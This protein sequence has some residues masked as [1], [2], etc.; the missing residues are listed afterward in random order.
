M[1]AITGGNTLGVFNGFLPPQPGQSRMGSTGEAAWVN[2]ANGNLVLQRTDQILN[3]TGFDT[4]LLRTYNSQARYA[5]DNQDGWWL[6]GYR[7]VLNQTG[8][9]N[10]SGSSVQRVDSDGA[11]QTYLWDGERYLQHDA[12]GRQAS[13]RWDATGSGWV[14]QQDTAT[15]RAERYET[16]ADGTWRL[17]SCTDA[18]GTVEVSYG[19][20][21]SNSTY[22]PQDARLLTRITAANGET[23]QLVYNGDL[24]MEEQVWHTGSPAALYSSTRYEYDS[25]RRLS[26]VMVDL[27]PED[28]SV[29]DGHVYATRYTYVGNGNLVASV[30]QTDGS[31]LRLGYVEVEG[32]DRVASMTD[33]LGYITLFSYNTAQRSTTVTDALGASTVY[34][35]D[36]QGRFE[37][38]TGPGVN[39]H[40]QQT[41]YTWDD[42]GNMT[43]Q[44]QASG[45]VITFAYDSRGH[46]VRQQDSAGN[47][48]E[49]YWNSLDQMT[50]R[51]T[52]TVVD[53]DGLAGPGQASGRLTTRYLYGETG[54]MEFMIS[55]EGT[56]S[57]YVYSG[58]KLETIE[59]FDSSFS[60]QP[61][62]GQRAPDDPF[63]LDD[64]ELL[65][66]GLNSRMSVLY[67]H[68]ARG[69]MILSRQRAANGVSEQVVTY[70]YD[71]FGNLLVRME[72]PEMNPEGIASYYSHDG[73]GRLLTETDAEG[74]TRVHVWD[75][76]GG[77]TTHTQANG[78][79]D[80]EL[81]DANGRL[82]STTQGGMPALRYAYDALG[83]QVLSVDAAGHQTRSLYD[84]NGNRVA[85][86]T[87]AGALTE[88]IY[89]AAGQCSGE[90]RYATLLSGLQLAA[91][92]DA[93]GTPLDP[94][95]AA[96][97]PGVTTADAS[98]WQFH[99]LAG[100]LALTVDGTGNVTSRAYDGVGNMISETR[101]AIPVSLP[102]AGGGAPL[103]P[104]ASDADR[105]HYFYHDGN[106]NL[107]GEIDAE[108]YVTRY[109]RNVFGQSIQT[110]RHATRLE[111]MPDAATPFSQLIPASTSADQ[112][113]FF[114]YSA[115][116]TLRGTVDA[117]HY[118]TEVAYDI[119]GNK[120][121]EIRH[122]KPIEFN[123]LVYERDLS[124]LTRRTTLAGLDQTTSYTWTRLNQLSSKTNSD[125]VR[126]EY[127]YDAMGQLTATT[128]AAGTLDQRQNLARYD[129]QG[130]MIAT[131]AGEGAYRLQ[132]ATTPAAID[133]VWAEWGTVYAYD[134]AGQQISSEIQNPDGSRNVTRYLYDDAGRLIATV[135][136]LGEASAQRWNAVGQL[137]ETR[138]YQQRLSTAQLS[139]LPGISSTGWAAIL[140]TLQHAE[141]RITRY[142]YDAAGRQSTIT[143]ALQQT[144]RTQYNA[145]GELARSIRNM[146]DGTQVATAYAYD[147]RGQVTQITEDEGGSLSRSTHTVYDPF[148]RVTQTMDAR[149][150]ATHYSYD[151]R[152]RQI[153]IRDAAGYSTSTVYDSRDRKVS[154]TDSLGNVTRWAYDLAS[155]T[156]T[157][158]EG[159]STTTHPNDFGQIVALTDGMGNVTRYEYDHSGQ[160]I[161]ST[162]VL[163]HVVTH[164]FNA[165]GQEW[166]T[167]DAMG[168]VTQS[169]YDPVGR[170]LSKTLDPAG[171]ALRTSWQ[172]DAL[173]QQLSVATG[174]TRQPAQTVT[175]YSYDALGQLVLATQDPDGLAIRT[176]Y[177]HD[178][179]GQVIAI[180]EAE[181][182]PAQKLT[183][184]TFDALG[185]RTS[186]TVDP[187]GLNI[188]TTYRYDAS[189]NLIERIADA[190]G[191]RATS[192]Y[193]Y[194]ALNRLTLSV[195]AMG[196]LTRT[197][198][199]SAGRVIEVKRFANA[200]DLTR[201]A[202][203]PDGSTREAAILAL[204]KPLSGKDPV[205]TS[206]YDRDGRPGKV[207]DA[208]GTTTTYTWNANGQRVSQHLSGT[209]TDQLTVYQLDKAGRTVAE[210]VAHGTDVAS[211][212]R[213][214]YDASG[215]LV[216]QTDPLGVE[217][218]ET[219]SAWA[220]AERQ[221]LHYVNDLGTRKRA[222]DLSEGERASLRGRYTT[223]WQYDTAGRQTSERDPL[224]GTTRQEQDARG[225]VVRMTDALGHTGYF[226]YDALNRLTGQVDPEGYLTTTQYSAN[227]QVSTVTRYMTRVSG[228]VSV[229]SMPP[230][231]DGASAVT[232]FSHDLMGRLLI[233]TDA[234]QHTERY[235]W[236]GL[237]HKTSYTNTLNAT[238][239]YQYD[240]R[241]L[242]LQETLPVHT[243][244]QTGEPVAVINRYE[245]DCFGNRSKVIEAA[246][247]REQRITTYSHDLLNRLLTTTGEPLRAD[248][249]QGS[250]SVT[251]TSTQSWNAAG[252]LLSV[253]DANGNTTRY[254]YDAANR[255]TGQRTADGTETR[256][257]LDAAGNVI[258]QTVTPPAGQG[259]ART[260]CYSYDANRQ[261][262]ETRIPQIR[263]ANRAADNK[264]EIHTGDLCTRTVYNAQ[265][266]AVETVDANGNTTYHFYDRTGH[267]LLQVDAAGYG[268]AWQ[269]DAEGHV[270]QETRYALGSTE[271]V[272]SGLEA[273]ALIRNWPTDASQDRTTQYTYDLLG[274]R[275]SETRLNVQ[276]GG[277]SSTGALATTTGG[278]STRYAYDNA[279][280]L[281][282]K[283]DAAHNIYR[284]QYDGLG[285]KTAD[286]LPVT[287]GYTGR[288]V[289]LQVDYEYN[290]LNQCT[291]EARRASGDNTDQITH[292]EYG[293]GGRL[294]RKTDARGTQF[295]FEYD[296][297]GNLTATRYVRTTNAG[298]QTE[299]IV[300]RYDNLNRETLRFTE[301][302]HGSSRVN[303]VNSHTA[304]NGFSEIT[305]RETG[306]TDNISAGPAEFTEYDQAG[307]V[308]RSNAGN[309]VTH[310][311]LYDANGNATVQYESQ[312]LDLRTFDFNNEATRVAAEQAGE[313]FKTI[314]LYDRRNQIEQIVQPDMSGLGE[315]P[316]LQEVPGKIMPGSYQ[317]GVSG[318]GAIN[319]TPLNTAAGQPA[320]NGGGMSAAALNSP[321]TASWVMQQAGGWTGNR[322]LRDPQTIS[323]LWVDTTVTVPDLRALGASRYNVRFEMLIDGVTPM[324][325]TMGGI[326]SDNPGQSVTLSGFAQ[327][328]TT[329]SSMAAWTPTIIVIA[330]VMNGN[331]REIARYQT[332]SAIATPAVT[333]RRGDWPWIKRTDA[334]SATCGQEG[335][336]LNLDPADAGNPRVVVA[337]RLGSIDAFQKLDS[338][339]SRIN[340]GVLANGDYEVLQIVTNNN[341]LQ[342]REALAVHKTASN[343]WSE[344]IP[345]NY[346]ADSAFDANANGTFLISS[347]YLYMADVKTRTGERGD[348]VEMWSRPKGST[349]ALTYKGENHQLFSAWYWPAQSGDHEIEIRIK[350]NG[351][352]LL[353]TLSGTFRGGAAPRISVRSQADTTASVLTITNL[354]LIADR[355]SS[356]T[357]VNANGYRMD[358]T[359][360][361]TL[362]A[363]GALRVDIPANWVST[364]NNAGPWT[365][366]IQ[367]TTGVERDVVYEG[368]GSIR[369]GTGSTEAVITATRSISAISF[370]PTI[371]GAAA[372][373]ISYRPTPRTEADQMAAS[374][375][376]TR[377]LRADGSV[378]FALEGLNPVLEVEYRYDILDGNGAVIST[379]DGYFTLNHHVSGKGATGYVSSIAT[380]AAYTIHRQQTHNAFGE[381]ASETDGR[382]Y[383]EGNAN[384]ALRDQY[385]TTLE[386]NTQG[387][388]T[389]KIA[390][391]VQ[392]TLANGYQQLARPETAYSY[393]VLG[394]VVAM[395][396]ANGNLTTQAWAMAGGKA[397]VIQEWHAD[398]GIKKYGYDEFGNRRSQTDEL[399][400]RTDYHYTQNNQIDQVDHPV[401]AG[402][403]HIQDR[404][405][406]DELGQRIRHTQT[407]GSLVRTD[408]TDYDTA[409]RVTRTVSAAGRITTLDFTHTMGHWIRTTTQANG[410]DV[411]GNRLTG[412][413]LTA[414]HS[415][416]V[417]ETDAFGRVIRHTGLGGTVSAYE[418]N[419]A[420]LLTRQDQT[421]YAYYGNGLVR[422]MT[423]TG[424]GNRG[425][426]E[427]DTDGNRV[428]E[429][430]SG[431]NNLYYYQTTAT[432]DG[433]NRLTHLHDGA[434]DASGKALSKGSLFDISYEFDAAGNRIRM[435]SIYR[436]A[437][438]GHVQS[439]DYWYA[440]DSL[441]RFT[442]T[443][444]RLASGS[445]ALSAAALNPVVSTGTASGVTLAYN[446]ASQRTAA[447]TASNGLTSYYSYD[448]NGALTET[449]VSDGQVFIRYNDAAGREF[450]YHTWNAQGKKTTDLIRTWDADNLL[451]DEQDQMNRTATSYERMRDGTL[452]A[453]Q[454]RA[455]HPRATTL[456]TVYSYVYFDS[457][458]QADIKI[459]ASNKTVDE[460]K[461]TW[462]PGKSS[463]TYDAYG[464]LTQARDVEANRTFSYDHDG[465]GKVLQRNEY[466]NN[467]AQ[468]RYHKYYYFEGH[469]VGNIG[470]DGIRNLDYVQE[471]AQRQQLDKDASHKRTGPVSAIDFTPDAVADFDSNYQPVNSSYPGLAPSSY[472][473]RA[474]DTLRSVAQAL[475]GDADM[476][477]LIADANGML[478]NDALVAGTVLTIP[479]RVTNIHNNAGTFKVYDPGRAIGN[480]QPTLPDPPPP[481]VPASSGNRCGVLGR[482]VL[483]VVAVVATIYTTGLAAESLGAALT[484]GG[485]SASTMALGGAALSGGTTLGMGAAIGAAA[486]GGAAGSVAAQGLN[487]LAGNQ[488]GLN[489]KGVAMGAVGTA[490]TAG[491]GSYFNAG[492]VAMLIKDTSSAVDYLS[493]A[494]QAALRS[495]ATQTI[496]VATGLQHNFD[497]Q[498][499]AAGAIAAGVAFGVGR[500]LRGTT[501]PAP[502]QRF[503]TGMA[504]GVISAEV[505]GNLNAENLTGIT[506]DVLGSTLGMQ[507]SEQIAAQQ[508]QRNLAE[509][510]KLPP[511]YWGMTAESGGG[512]RNDAGPVETAEANPLRPTNT[513]AIKL[514]EK[515]SPED[516]ALYLEAEK[517]IAAWP[518]TPIFDAED[519]H[520]YLLM[521]FFDGTGNDEL[522]M[523]IPTNVSEL[524]KLIATSKNVW[525]QYYKGVGTDP[526]T[527]IIGG[528]TGAG[529]SNRINEAYH[530]VIKRANQIYLD[531]PNAKLTFVSVGFSRGSAIGRIYSNHMGEYGI[532][533][534]DSI[535]SV[536]SQDGSHTVYDRYLVEPGKVDI[537]AQIL[538]DTVSTGFGDLYNLSILESTQNV[539]H[540]TARDEFRH[541]FGLTSA[542]DSPQKSDRRI[543]EITLPGAHSDIGGSYDRGGLGDMNL[544][545]AQ[546]YTGKLGIP[547]K[548]KN[549]TLK[550]DLSKAII[551]D[552][553]WLQ[554]KMRETLFSRSSR[555]IDY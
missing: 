30:T 410:F 499:L 307:R 404:Y 508:M 349:G 216:A 484:A 390:P 11:V 200:L 199:D 222:A 121:R 124:W 412:E 422:D 381:I 459:Q 125:G 519:P 477:W 374:T 340:L 409:G 165:Q 247:A 398:G 524:R 350:R 475:W 204:S 445:R 37:S 110:T 269:Y 149:G 260:T 235:S 67:N 482:I 39:G 538:F 99:D 275:T 370:T 551:H 177:T 470:N 107:A 474:G 440:Y 493:V 250:R 365:M 550:P 71:A 22:G 221:A 366:E 28:M 264:V 509:S 371:P 192:R 77:R 56:T 63:T 68:D 485:T 387:Q 549:A 368:K 500:G 234:S 126:T 242:L 164:D 253:T 541:G 547:L 276:T 228:P 10:T 353:D 298:S 147:H 272:T 150:K 6:N 406:V 82:I 50:A 352:V 425:H 38:V 533:D 334:T 136:A 43:S 256:Y 252:R 209:G 144:T 293:T 140:A 367:A 75:D 74:H 328:Q 279:G 239:A 357:L 309:G 290:G 530:D 403:Q 494:G 151:S 215:R 471:M 153:Q 134:S 389:R 423:D 297:N 455:D 295:D 514:G 304:Y 327:R 537:G 444:G 458:Q 332:S 196:G 131:L 80:T 118:F 492:N 294:T 486:I 259:A 546:E 408:T 329:A 391:Q 191:A 532:P 426:Y 490:V 109:L 18:S 511:G 95:L 148:G 193:A 237:G 35:H 97:R 42:A 454:T 498:G 496:G 78:R 303:G 528:L 527:E 273:G 203:L 356:F 206:S 24:L 240:L 324:Y 322:D 336:W 467:N 271:V 554:D 87:P 384:K 62:L 219:D 58:E 364:L 32:T 91:L 266:Q 100:R 314:T 173:G 481:P 236:N 518:V 479:N 117:A 142:T 431:R 347:Q 179:R 17:A 379:V 127:A 231:P 55:P 418:Y 316:G 278:V 376:A 358:L 386:Y 33:A 47:V 159:I 225:N 40:A 157:T 424:S 411:A 447:T 79:T 160:L 355:I 413:A 299:R 185:R 393:D 132:G 348:Y 184:Y 451:L 400:L 46:L 542:F 472:T 94:G 513:N 416:L 243:R 258:S 172:W 434:F 359:R 373:R 338:Y 249:A 263:Q 502:A 545:F 306:N 439:Q 84:A 72:H 407:A 501:L 19:Y 522:K 143:D 176:R 182:T 401:L 392:I 321:M 520:Q 523:E 312:A 133:A 506:G 257:T 282:Q 529:I 510:T 21:G 438:G 362:Q 430:Y 437:L 145:F 428:F 139:Q 441:N 525:A 548:P 25:Q 291:Q 251:P 59:C 452:L 61:G 49:Q 92:Y 543:L 123:G 202:S 339:G 435:N 34:V 15:R 189:D 302:M 163:G 417:D 195:D 241:G 478:G 105:T 280:N 27:S 466:I 213:Y 283:T 93:T 313:L 244:N 152:G 174:T 23:V 88:F 427:Y 385:T 505:R 154:S 480:T 90:I 536:Q 363:G 405:T 201:L 76:A 7:R 462:A 138:R 515:L 465:E 521:S 205:E 155:F 476:W 233:S 141:D 396:D 397:Q 1:V 360:Y 399:G 254:D 167:T 223:T 433:M 220:S 414:S 183:Q 296:A 308:F 20:G 89:D 531:D 415:V 171:L 54:Q 168:V 330:H 66:D 450:A 112:V 377:N 289:Q 178:A 287:T 394:N 60:S 473:A 158:P 106:G 292:F 53:P 262:V 26:G 207:T 300:S 288:A 212:T 382:G 268:I 318:S 331:E 483:V 461:K 73:L 248:D 267:K 319:A 113:D 432:W 44:T 453:T 9:L 491:V 443:M 305:G 552:S 232:Q 270:L 286:I 65:L 170:L 16:A 14:W 463:F 517:T 186:E 284:W 488:S 540:L 13:L 227:G 208:N 341:G 214:R 129:A 255:K 104:A 512:I 108:G 301:V 188:T 3:A 446:R 2:T 4:A 337:R 448:N 375:V 320:I 226:Y 383:S 98:T 57:S 469:E 175:R 96:L 497:W 41:R 342:R 36:A 86:I 553:R 135:N 395:Q 218:A 333:S 111:H 181:G 230:L 210:T 146:G 70:Y 246:G 229:G 489:W 274:R 119:R 323:Q 421:T 169:D 31:T 130:R 346:T 326:S 81:R 190:S 534:L 120:L 503:A 85:V 495:A 468:N 555:S 45:L 380:D 388:L 64:L 345:A 277:I 29:A 311:W 420:G 12:N 122:G 456:R 507:V 487:I 83:R 114:I 261:L 197:S 344:A 460:W 128:S 457:A 315:R 317:L 52:Y 8:N 429:G 166:Q 544:K 48:L 442:V 103:L 343:T 464:R 535:R 281:V 198:H 211:T 162:D 516:I 238:T 137:A 335:S 115:E 217:L 402:D 539:L 194:D 187:A 101:H 351:G 526:G 156:V 265:G 369:F 419:Y 372:I 5:D 285:R 449:R 325:S 51:V 102:A 504:A 245:Y 161:R 310:L 224:G 378:L 436:D 116:G 361:A 180:T 69:R 354:K